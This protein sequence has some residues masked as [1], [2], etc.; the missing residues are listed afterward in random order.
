MASDDNKHSGGQP[1][2]DKRRMD[3]PTFGP[4]WR[5]RMQ[6]PH[7]GGHQLVREVTVSQLLIGFLVMM[8]VGWLS[9]LV[10]SG[11]MRLLPVL[12][13]GGGAGMLVGKMDS[14]G[15]SVWK[16]IYRA[17]AF[18]FKCR[19]Y[20]GVAPVGRSKRKKRLLALVAI[21][22]GRVVREPGA[23]EIVY[24]G[25]REIGRGLLEAY[26]PRSRKHSRARLRARLR[27]RSRGPRSW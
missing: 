15:R 10:M 26:D 4:L 2:N 22:Q 21:T 13:A 25:L 23:A 12:I 7:I 11:P 17:V 18:G 1:A 14:G 16:T 3:M 20:H 19:L 9:G 6:V 8:F 24:A 27:K 5:V